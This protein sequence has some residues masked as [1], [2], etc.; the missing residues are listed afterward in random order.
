MID[1]EIIESGDAYM[2]CFIESFVTIWSTLYHQSKT[3]QAFHPDI[4]YEEVQRQLTLCFQKDKDFLR[5][6]EDGYPVDS[7]R[8]DYDS[9]WSVCDRACEVFD[10]K[11]LFH[12]HIDGYLMRDVCDRKL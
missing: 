9:E 10:S 5:F 2:F 6:L 7:F 12:F 4:P 1:D 11:F 3:T 8:W